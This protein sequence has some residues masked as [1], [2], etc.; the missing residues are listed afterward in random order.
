MPRMMVLCVRPALK[1]PPRHL[2]V[3]DTLVLRSKDSPAMVVPSIL[4]LSY[5]DRVFM[6]YKPLFHLFRPPDFKPCLLVSRALP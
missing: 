2:P 3:S 4:L 1:F 6:V 5:Y